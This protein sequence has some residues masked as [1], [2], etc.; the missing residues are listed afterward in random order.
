MKLK[1]RL[2]VTFT[3]ISIIPFIAGMCFMLFRSGKTIRQNALGFLE[4]YANTIASD[5]SAFFAEKRGFVQSCAL[6][7]EVQAMNWPLVTQAMETSQDKLATIDAITTYMLVQTDGSYY[8]SDSLG[9]PA[10]GGRVS[11]DNEDPQANLTLV[12][13]RDYFIRLVTQNPQGSY[14]TFV[15]DP[16][17]SRSTGQ[18]QIVVAATIR[19]REGSNGGLFALML[20]TGSL[21]SLLD[22]ITRNIDT[23]FGNQVNLMLMS[24]SGM[25]ASIREYDPSRAAYV[26]TAL[27]VNQDISSEDLSP[28]MANALQNLGEEENNQYTTFKHET[29]QKPYIMIR[30]L[31]TGTDYEVVLTIPERV[32]FRA[33][34]D[35][36]FIALFFLLGIILIL[37]VVVFILNNRIVTPLTRTAAALRDIS[38][39]SGNLTE[40]LTV[41]GNDEIS[42][43]G[44]YFN[45]FMST[46]QT[47]I[48]EVVQQ[49]RRIEKVSRELEQYSASIVTE[50]AAISTNISNLHTQTNEQ[51]DIVGK[52]ISAVQQ[53]S[54]SIRTL[55]QKIESQTAGI[56]ES[57]AAVHQMAANIASISKHSLQVKTMFQDLITASED[58]KHNLTGVNVLVQA[59]AEQSSQLLDTNKV[60][61]AIASKTNLLAMN[62]SIEAAHAGTAGRGFAVVATEIGT[63]A[64]NATQQ[65]KMIRDALKQSIATITEIVSATANA[66]SSFNRISQYITQVNT[67]IEEIS[68]AMIEQEEGSHQVLEAL[69]LIQKNTLQ[70]RDESVEMNTDS[71]AILKAMSHLEAASHQVQQSTQGIAEFTGN[72]DKTVTHIMEVSYKNAGIVRELND[73]TDRFKV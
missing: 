64:A 36:T 40:R 31:V 18:K 68:L 3:V 61:N 54:E 8:R 56:T 70:I 53:I 43:V 71:T 63:L 29:T 41:V 48:S 34:Y 52:A 13:N 72:I 50:V 60:I 19:T 15:S 66:D 21:N 6:Y 32:L 12:N 45:T 62:A 2:A 30:A 1:K 46:L 59:L 26:E 44:I 10:L 23:N 24:R 16:N 37:L 69:E 35:M 49:E 7:P 28:A 20:N 57:S 22:T 5:V 4:E 11:A 65:S 33:L 58:G 17:I 73:L 9:N 38:E 47:L 51:E 67:L 25:V 55:S 42:D 27:Q 14:R 39:G